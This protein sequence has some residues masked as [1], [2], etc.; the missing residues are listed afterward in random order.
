MLLLLCLVMH[1]A[2]AVLLPPLVNIDSGPIIGKRHPDGTITYR[3]IPFAAPPTGT[4]RFR[5]PQKHDSWFLP[6]DAAGKSGPAC[7]Q[8]DLVARVHRGV[9]DCL[10]LDVTVPPQCQ[11]GPPCAVMQF[12]YGGAW[13]LGDKWQF[14]EYNETA[15]ASRGVII[16]IANY[17]VDVFAGLALAELA[18]ESPD[19][20]STGNVALL[21]QRYALEWTQRNIHVF[22][23]DKARVTIFGG[24]TGAFS[25]CSHYVSPASRGLFAQAIMES[26]S[27]SSA[28][29]TDTE[30]F[31]AKAQAMA[32]GRLYAR[33]VG[34]NQTGAALLSCLRSLRP[35]DLMKNFLAPLKKNWN[36]PFKPHT[37]TLTPAEHAALPPLAPVIPWGFVVDGS[38]AG[39]PDVPLNMIRRGSFAK[40]PLMAGTNKDE[41]TIFAPMV[42]YAVPNASIPISPGSLLNILHHVWNESTVPRILDFYTARKYCTENWPAITGTCSDQRGSA[43]ITDSH[44]F[45]GT[46]QTM[47]AVSSQGIPAYFYHFDQPVYPQTDRRYKELGVNHGAQDKFV[48]QHVTD[49]AEPSLEHDKHAL[50]M[51]IGAWW[52]NFAKHGDPNGDPNGEPKSAGRDHGNTT[53]STTE[54]GGLTLPFWVAYSVEEDNLMGMRYPAAMRMPADDRGACKALW[55]LL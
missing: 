9:E 4:L 17:R 30:F 14:G 38:E 25:V 37:H 29:G 39:L 8:L 28:S 21:D 31:A 5:A 12:I 47:A 16:V 49:A 51:Q 27:C 7:S 26:A 22:G 2:S 20:L 44:F 46:R 50:S 11:Q 6:K 34:C 41:G 15:L 54:A 19:G 43:C 35:G 45:C 13:M 48:F 40:V 1:M 3:G 52:T 23:G 36:W 33:S 32:F 24:S 53:H 10:T 18:E 55:D 42:T